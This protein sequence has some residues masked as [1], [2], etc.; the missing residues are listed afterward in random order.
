MSRITTEEALSSC[1]SSE[2][3]HF[4]LGT[5]CLFVTWNIISDDKP[6]RKE[7]QS[8]PFLCVVFYFF[9]LHFF[10]S[11][12]QSLA[13]RGHWAVK[14]WRGSKLW[15]GVGESLYSQKKKKKKKDKWKSVALKN[16]PLV[17]RI[18]T[19]MWKERVCLLSL[20]SGRLYSG[21]QPIRTPRLPLSVVWSSPKAPMSAIHLQLPLTHFTFSS[22]AAGSFRIERRTVELHS[23]TISNSKWLP[24]VLWAFLFQPKTEQREKKKKGNKLISTGL[25]W[26]VG[27]GMMTYVLV[28]E[29]KW[30]MI[31]L[32]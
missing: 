19:Y 8:Q 1:I 24:R 27:G 32:W 2:S 11:D 9:S 15:G 12:C 13:G 5:D 23:Q 22:M 4:V 14:C 18:K 7:T 21:S 26:W 10:L 25:W 20:H 17:W 28:F 3:L 6:R 31:R 30:W 29:K 16:S